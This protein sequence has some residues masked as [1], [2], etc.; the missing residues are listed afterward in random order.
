MDMYGPPVDL[1]FRSLAQI[2]DALAAKPQNRHRSAKTNSEGKYVCCSMILNNNKL[3]NLVGFL[4]VLNHFVDQPLKLMWLDMS[5]NKLKS[6]DPVL[7]KLHELR[8]LY[9]HGN[10]IT[11]IAEVDKL[12]ELQHLRTITLHGNEIENQKGYRRYVISNLTQLK[13]MDF[14][15]VTRDERVMAGIWRHSKIQSKG[16][17]E[18][19]H[20]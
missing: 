20:D 15:A 10:R 11:K 13:M 3:P 19:S 18:S 1:S 8:V 12:K 14:S 17:K 5:F 7:C 16:T 2:S 9:L 4:D 6:I